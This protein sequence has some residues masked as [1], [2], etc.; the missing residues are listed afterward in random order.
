MAIQDYQDSTFFKWNTDESGEKIVAIITNE[1]KKIFNNITVLNQLPDSFEKVTIT[2]MYEIKI[3]QTIQNNTQFKVDYN[4]GFIYF[5]PDKD[6]TTITIARYGGRGIWLQPSSRIWY[7]LTSDG[8]D[9]TKTLQNVIDESIEAINNTNTVANSLIFRGEYSDTT[10]YI[11]RNFITYNNQLYICKQNSTGN[12]PTNTTYWEKVIN[13][14]LIKGDYDNS[15]PYTLFNIVYY[16]GSSYVCISPCTGTTPTNTTYWQLIAKSAEGLKYQGVYDNAFTYNEQ[17]FISY[18]DLLYYCKATSLGNLPTD[19]N[20]FIILPFP[21]G[22]PTVLTNVVTVGGSPVSTV[23]IGISS[24]NSTSDYLRVVE[25]TTVIWK[26]EEYTISGTTINKISGT[27]NAGTVFYIE[28]LKN[29]IQDLFYSDGS[30]LQNGSVNK[31]KL[32]TD[33]QDSLANY[34]TLLI[35]VKYPPSPL[36]VA[37]GDGVADDFDAIQ[38]AINYVNAQGGG[39]VYI[40]KGTYLMGNKTM[41]MKSNVKL[42]GEHGQTIIKLSELYEA[43]RGFILNYSYVSG[44]VNEY[45]DQ[46]MTFKNIIFDGNNNPDRT[47][48]MVTFYKSKNLVF[49]N[50]T[51]QNHTMIGLDIEGCYDVNIDGCHFFNCGRPAPTTVSSPAIHVSK[52][53]TDSTECKYINIHNCLF[54]DNNW[55]GIYFAPQQGQ[56][57]N[58]RFIDNGESSIYINGATSSIISNNYIKGARVNNISGTGI[59]TTG[60]DLIIS[61]NIIEDCQAGGISLTDCYQIEMRE[62]IIKNN[63]LTGG[64]ANGITIMSTDA[65]HYPRNI[66]INNNRIYDDRVPKIQNHAIQINT[67]NHVVENMFIFD[68]DLRE[69]LGTPINNTGVWGTGCYTKN[70]LGHNSIAPYIGVVDAP[71][72]PQNVVVTGIDFQPSYIEFETMEASAGA[73]ITCKTILTRTSS[74]TITSTIDNEGTISCQVGVDGWAIRTVNTNGTVRC[75][76]VLVSMNNDG[77]TLD[78]LTTEAQPYI[79]FTAHP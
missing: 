61:N 26:D 22:T 47:V 56:I 32:T 64:S 6:G 76:A 74:K 27:W 10:S 31:Y 50:V 12:L 70:N 75:G 25:N 8:A 57:H 34:A 17:D 72:T 78:F 65:I 48:T 4:Y 19:T 67:M 59:E 66:K 37:T 45:I 35:N 51:F 3:S 49:K 73:I 68:N 38:D 20:Y 13:G 36:A 63:G 60:I 9:V 40:P 5:H 2:G 30:M 55:S 29:V 42:L 53:T 52:A 14:M 23:D 41:R 11:I 15:T 71:A 18:N 39:T 77:F 79:M 69:N 62:N 54:Q 7:E 46:N 16:L 33:I 58:C 44:G 43:G 21:Q 24:F 1:E 28:V